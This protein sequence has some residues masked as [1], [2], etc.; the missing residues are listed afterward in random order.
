MCLKRGDFMTERTKPSHHAIGV[1]VNRA[2]IA[3]IHDNRSEKE[4]AIKK[5][6]ELLANSGT[7]AIAVFSEIQNGK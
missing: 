2:V 1:E 6:T 4:T 7:Q 3:S 5:L